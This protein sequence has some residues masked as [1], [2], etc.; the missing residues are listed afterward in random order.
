MGNTCTPSD[1]YGSAVL[2]RLQISW[3]TTCCVRCT[4]M[5]SAFWMVNTCLC[6][7]V[8]TC[9]YNLKNHPKKKTSMDGHRLHHLPGNSTTA[10]WCNNHLE[11]YESQ[12]E[13][14]HPINYG[15]KHVWN[16]QPDKNSYFIN[17]IKPMGF[18]HKKLMEKAPG[19]GGGWRSPPLSSALWVAAASARC[20]RCR[21][22]RGEEGWDDGR[23]PWLKQ[24]V[25][26]I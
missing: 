24:D 22:T 23:R 14:W 9:V 8:P 2:E 19:K 6:A 26:R 13:G 7:C 1:I 17:P 12:W 15:K 11:E 21:A 16:H 4:S 10:W 18:S 5:P 25:E 20:P 3:E